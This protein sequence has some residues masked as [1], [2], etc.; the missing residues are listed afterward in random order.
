MPNNF[1]TESKDMVF[2]D[3]YS[4]LHIVKQL[5]DIMYLGSETLKIGLVYANVA[6]YY[7]YNR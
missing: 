7:T 4:T 3:I 1:I 2:N 5:K 6:D